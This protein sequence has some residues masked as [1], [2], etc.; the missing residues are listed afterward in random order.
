MVF[1]NSKSWLAPTRM[2][3]SARKV[4]RVWG[5]GLQVEGQIQKNCDESYFLEN[6]VVRCPSCVAEQSSGC[7]LVLL[8]HL[9]DPDHSQEG[10]RSPVWRHKCLGGADPRKSVAYL[11]WFG[12]KCWL[13][14]PALSD[15]HFK[16]S[17]DSSPCQTSGSRLERQ[18][19]TTT[20][21]WAELAKVIEPN[22]SQEQ[23][24]ASQEGRG[25]TGSLGGS[26]WALGRRCVLRMWHSSTTDGQRGHEL[27]ILEG[28]SHTK[29]WLVQN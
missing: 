26:G 20:A 17:K 6:R 11:I 9:T 5:E 1:F 2:G 28:L 18:H 13:P 21:A 25:H 29:P 16:A 22:S 19:Q 10:P 15:Q 24:A 7:P 3:F 23:Q 14:S 27:S 4:T 8:H 12:V